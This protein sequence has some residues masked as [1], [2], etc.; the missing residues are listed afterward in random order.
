MLRKTK[1]YIHGNQ[2]YPPTGAIPVLMNFRPD[3]SPILV[4]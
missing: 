2:I 3:I 4:L 1:K